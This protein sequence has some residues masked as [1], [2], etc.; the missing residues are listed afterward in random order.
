MKRREQVSRLVAALALLLVPG[1]SSD[2]GPTKAQSTIGPAG[3][4]VTVG[5][6]SVVIPQ[7]ATGTDREIGIEKLGSGWP[8]APAGLELAGDVYAFTPHGIG[9]AS[10]V[11]VTIPVNATTSDVKLYKYQP[12]ES[13]WTEVSGATVNASDSTITGL[14]S[15]FSGFC[16]MKT[17]KPS[18][19]EPTPDMGPS[20]DK[21]TPEK[22]MGQCKGVEMQCDTSAECCTGLECID[23][24]GYKGCF[25]PS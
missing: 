23:I 18:G 4:S 25:T 17:A 5:K 9:F 19:G 12:G 14:T 1:C 10:P 7:G 21:G 6:A 20:G 22:D 8:D 3:G 16:G 13:V 11:T 24:S 2:D 15:S